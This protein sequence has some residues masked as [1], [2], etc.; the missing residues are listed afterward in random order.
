MTSENSAPSAKIRLAR[1]E[2]ADRLTRLAMTA[3]A[4][5]GY[6]EAFMAMCRAELT[7]TPEKMNAWTIWVAECVGEI[8]GMIALASKGLSGEVEDFMVDPDF[9]G[10]GL[11]AALMGALLDECRAR[12]LQ[13]IGLDADP[14]A[15][16]IYQR[17]GLT[18]V[19]QSPSRSI[20][21]RMLPRMVLAV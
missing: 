12:G 15:E 7:L 8:V 13:T 3:K 6:D 11:G 10:R 9:Q 20:P 2:E 21:G 19:G 14:N 4:S 1:P 5:W 16:G 17:L 18:T